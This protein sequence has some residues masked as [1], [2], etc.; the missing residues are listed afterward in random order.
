VK[1]LWPFPGDSPVARARKVALAYRH[2]AQQQHQ[3]ANILAQAMRKADT[4]LLAYDSPTTL[5]EIKAALKVFDASDPVA[6]LDKRFTDWGETFH[7]E[8]PVHYDMDDYVK[9]EEAA[10]LIHLSRKSMSA[11]RVRGRIK[12]HW[13]PDIGTSGGYLYLVRDVYALSTTLK[14]RSKAGAEKG[15]QIPSTTTG[16]VTPHERKR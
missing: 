6:E 13:T 14:S 7:T 16:E 4:R 9:A 10:A 8:A 1:R 15:P 3:A 5:E 11:L 2:V 12:G